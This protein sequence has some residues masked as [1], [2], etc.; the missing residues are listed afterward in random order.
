MLLGGTA[1]AW[2]LAAGAQQTATPV[3][4]LLGSESP[5]RWASR[6]E[7]FHQGLNETGYVDGRNVAIEYRWAEGQNDRL[8]ALAADLVRRRVTVIAAPGSTPATLAAKAATSTIP[9]VFW[10]GGD[11]IELGLVGSMNRPGGNLTGLTTLNH[12]LVTKRME[13]LHEV[14]PGTSS[15]AVLINPT[16]PTLSKITVEEAQ[17][18]ARGLGLQLHI[19]K[20]STEREL[21]GVFDNLVQLR[22]GGLVLG[23]DAFFSGRLEQLAALSVRYGVP[24][25]YQF[26][27]F[28]AAGGLMGYGGS[29]A[30][31]FGGTGVY[32][33][34]ILKGDRPADLPVQQVTRLEL[35]INL[36]TAKAL[37]LH[38]P[39]HLIGRAD[40]VFE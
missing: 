17:T 26:R 3:I 2:P 32:T 20:A 7:A 22:A 1:A 18:A 19:L 31:A 27:E 28:A 23:T 5:G 9:I 25:V 12:G 34:R 37:R 33:G 38:L 14:A 6:M 24:M 10:V 39:L 16:S 13:L 4:G 21:E 35:Y 36:Q 8:P 40:E 15:M 29:L 11:P 30:E